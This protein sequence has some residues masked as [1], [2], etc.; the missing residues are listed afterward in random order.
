MIDSPSA[1][2]A[3]RESDGQL[4][5]I[6]A[7]GRARMVDVSGKPATHRVAVAS[8]EIRTRADLSAC[9]AK[10]PGGLD[11]VEGAR[12]AGIQAAKQTASLIPLCHPICL[13]GVRIEITLDEGRVG[14][15]ATTEVTERTGVEMEALTA[16]AVSALSL[17]EVVLEQ[18]PTASMEELT[19]WYKSGGRSG[20]WQRTGPDDQMTHEATSSAMSAK[21]PDPST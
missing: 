4:T 18:D 20:V 1:A 10:P 8:C 7:Q 13:E 15:T 16:A 12:F 14:I 17:M 11:P 5:H 21:E 3:D 6:D 2:G 19:L 9:L